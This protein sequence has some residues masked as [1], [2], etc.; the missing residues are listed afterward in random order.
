VNKISKKISSILHIFYVCLLICI[1]LE[2]CYYR[3]P[4]LKYWLGIKIGSLRPYLIYGGENT[5]MHLLWRFNKL[6]P[7]YKVSCTLKWGYD[8]DNLSKSI[9]FTRNGNNSNYNYIFTGLTPGNRYYYKLSDIAVKKNNKDNS[10][11]DSRG[12][13]GSFFA[14]PPDTQTTLKFTVYGDT[15]SVINE[16]KYI[17]NLLK[18]TYEEEK[19]FQTFVILVGDLVRYGLYPENYW[20]IHFFNPASPLLAHVPIQAVPGN[21]EFERD[22]WKYPPCDYGQ[23]DIFRSFFPYPYQTE[24]RLYWSFDY[25]PAH[26]V[27]LD[28]Y[29]KVEQNLNSGKQ[30]R[31]GSKQFAW[32]KE[33]LKRSK[34][35][36][37]FLVLH[38]P[39]WTARNEYNHDLR[40]VLKI[41]EEDSVDYG[42]DVVLA[43]H[44]HLYARAVRNGIC[45]ITTGG[46]GAELHKLEKYLKNKDRNTAVDFAIK[47]YHYCKIEI[48]GDSLTVTV[49]GKEEITKD[50]IDKQNKGEEFKG[51]QL[52]RF[53][54]RK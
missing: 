8:P 2:G 27:M 7:G 36:W 40:R 43:G 49:I 6:S 9:T 24:D 45:H 28:Q 23:T 29:V 10:V 46:G 50:D 32:L 47:A 48:D 38:E 18:K 5:E 26:F 30:H 41:L 15:R 19:D 12:F 31:L 54:I 53:T 21:H 44:V 16:H 20:R 1:L 13:K 14:A 4:E 52:D 37:K 51:Y 11:L 3:L 17:S 42:I 22:I 25:G 33:D 34:K 39:A 35:R